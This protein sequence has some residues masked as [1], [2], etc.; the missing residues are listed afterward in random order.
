MPSSIPNPPATAVDIR[1]VAGRLLVALALVASL[2]ALDPSTFVPGQDPAAAEALDLCALIFECKD[3]SHSTLEYLN[4][5]Q[6]ISSATSGS[7]A[8]VPYAAPAGSWLT[9]YAFTNIY[10]LVPSFSVSGA[11]TVQL[12]FEDSEVGNAGAIVEIGDGTCNVAAQASKGG[13]NLSVSYDIQGYRY[14]QILTW[15]DSIAYGSFASGEHADILVH[16]T[17]TAPVQVTTTGPCSVNFISNV[18]PYTHLYRMIAGAGNGRCDITANQPAGTGYIA[19]TPITRRFNIY[20]PGS[21]LVWTPG[22]EPPTVMTYPSASTVTVG[23]TNVATGG[24]VELFAGGA[25]QAAPDPADAS[26]FVIT[27]IAVGECVLNADA[28]VF[29]IR[30]DGT[31]YQPTLAA[32]FPVVLGNTPPI[33]TFTVSQLSNTAPSLVTVDGSASS[34]PDGD[35]LTYAWDLGDGTGGTDPSA[36]TTYTTAGQRTISLTVTD[37]HGASATATQTV[38]VDP[39][40]DT[41]PPAI[42]PNVVGTLGTNGW[43]R[44]DVDVT[45]TVIDADS[46]VS[47]SNGCDAVSLTTDTDGTTLTCS[48]TSAGGTA[49]QSVTIARDAT[50]PSLAPT[51]TPDPVPLGSSATATPGAADALSGLASA[52]CDTPPTAVLGAASVSCTATDLAGNTSTA[53]VSYTVVDPSPPTVLPTVT[54]TLGTNGWYTSDVTVTWT[55]TDPESAIS[56]STGCSTATVTA[57]TPA[58]TFTCAA[59]SAGGTA[60]DSVTVKRDATAPVLA[61]AVAPN[62]VGI[63]KVATASANATDSGSGIASSSCATPSTNS[64]G[65]TSVMCTATDAAG[66]TASSP[67]SYTVVY[68]W[69]GFVGPVDAPPV[70]NRVGAGKAIP[71][72]FSLGGNFSLGI[73]AA[74]APSSQQ[75]A[76][77]GSNVRRD[78]IETTVKAKTSTLTYLRWTGLY[79]YT[80]KTDP[81]WHGTCRQLTLAFADGSVRTA[82]FQFG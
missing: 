28:M 33:A 65:A 62:P 1:R 42:T 81:R 22:Y 51:I 36:S 4:I 49:Y 76:C 37:A 39:T 48:A 11:C 61:P 16:S 41:T 19:A 66:N 18:D 6:W 68:A 38:Q 63:H 32:S 8:E 43:Y 24:G 26:R 10:G 72:S 59:T 31:L 34:D 15:V 50:A 25:C 46:A 71:V 14:P 12:P 75:V 78:T 58:V 35:P 47:S 73:F 29:F 45:W 52:S 77:P 55:V 79:T 53:S 7:A 69:S 54:G 82:V 60:T 3:A 20:L 27:T 80:W 64:L 5:E 21:L 13:V 57:D 2:V 44:S 17:S 67:T 56:S 9:L 74:G 70:V 23:L 40:P 30:A